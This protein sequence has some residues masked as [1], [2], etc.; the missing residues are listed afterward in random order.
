MN[1]IIGIGV[2]GVFVLLFAVTNVTTIT[3]GENGLYKS[4]NGVI[5]P[6][7]LTEGFQFDGLGSIEKFNTRRITVS[8]DDL[9]PKTKNG[10]VMKDVEVTVTYSVAPTALFEFYTGYDM[11]NHGVTNNGQILLMSNY[12][13]KLITSAVSQ[14]FDETDSLQVNANLEKIQDEI[15]KNLELA[16][17]KKSLD[18][19][20]TINSVI[21]GKADL[22]DSL[23]DSLNRVVVAESAFREQEQKT[24]TA[25]SKADEQRIL[26]QSVTPL[27]LEYQRNE[28][29]REMFKSGSIKWGLINGASIDFLP[30]GQ[31]DS[32]S[33]P[34]ANKN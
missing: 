17:Q 25:Q 26:A 6:K 32:S 21:V 1:S 23:V 2:A 10:T 20:I 5:E 18:G 19:K 8:A 24:K 14:S 22:P 7:V 11:S 34:K 30:S 33:M 9:K 3:T 15:Q 29:M 12:I 4:F 16:L 28:I 27:A 31:F 13:S